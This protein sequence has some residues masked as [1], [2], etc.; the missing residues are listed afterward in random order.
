MLLFENISLSLI[1]AILASILFVITISFFLMKRRMHKLEARLEAFQ[2]LSTR[3]IKMVNQGAIGI[4]RRFAAIEK[5]LKKPE[6]VANFAQAHASAQEK[7][8]LRS[9]EEPVPDSTPEAREVK[10]QTRSARRTR[11]EQALSAWLNDQQTA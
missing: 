10:T 11:A 9:A 6:K 4:G 7:L 1:E 8:Q 2:R 5:D 3:E